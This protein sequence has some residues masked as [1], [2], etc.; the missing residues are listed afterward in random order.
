MEFLQFLVSHKEIAAKTKKD[1]TLQQV[2]MRA[3]AFWLNISSNVFLIM[4]RLKI[5]SN[6]S[7]SN[8]VRI[9]IQNFFVIKFVPSMS[10]VV[11]IKVSRKVYADFSFVCIVSDN[12]T[13][14]KNII[15]TEFCSFLTQNEVTILNLPPYRPILRKMAR[16]IWAL[17]KRAHFTCEVKRG[18]FQLLRNK[19]NEPFF[20]SQIKCAVFIKL[21]WNVPFFPSSNETCLFCS[22]GRLYYMLMILWLSQP[23]LIRWI[24]LN[25]I[26]WLSLS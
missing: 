12:G 21:K 3:S 26:S 17:E 9:P 8:Q 24:F 5:L 11:L 16:F 20:T 22:M 4:I 19:R 6:L 15:S 1:V 14:Q 25:I 23:V 2:F 7:V 13:Q 18:T 10:A